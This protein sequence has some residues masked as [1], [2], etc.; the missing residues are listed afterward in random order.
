MS[1]AV[2]RLLFPSGVRIIGGAQYAP[3]EVAAFP[4]DFA[5]QL[6]SLGLGQRVPDPPVEKAPSAPAAD[7]MVK[8]APVKKGA[9]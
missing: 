1:D 7:K 8:G 6:I 2:V 3:G 5:E 4:K 9:A